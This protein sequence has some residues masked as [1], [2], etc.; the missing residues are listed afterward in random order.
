ML[1]QLRP[2]STVFLDCLPAWFLKLGVPVFCKPTAYLFNLYITE[3][4]VPQQWKTAWI[5]P[6]HKVPVP[7]SHTDY[8]PISI[9]SILSHIMERLV[10]RQ[11]LYPAFSIQSSVFSDQY[12][13]HPSGSTTAAII[14]IL[15]TVTQLLADNDYVII[16]ALDFSKPF[17]TV[18]YHTL[19]EKLAN[20]AIPDNTYNWLVQFFQGH[21]HCTKFG[22]QTS[23]SRRNNGKYR[24]GLCHWARILRSHFL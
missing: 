18:R 15:Q 23:C 11:F 7:K 9:T 20:L 8:R 3:C 2:T 1:D 5:S 12:A 14:S 19:F 17:Y 16:L 24:P 4:F 21:S 10:V 13:F 6:I 22:N